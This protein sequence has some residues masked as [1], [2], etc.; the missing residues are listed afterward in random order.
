MRETVPDPQPRVAAEPTDGPAEPIARGVYNG[1]RQLQRHWQQASLPRPARI[2]VI[3]GAVLLLI[4]NLEWLLPVGAVLTLFYLPYLAVF[5]MFH[6]HKSP[7][8]P[9]VHRAAAVVRP[10]PPR[11]PAAPRQRRRRQTSRAQ[12]ETEARVSLRERTLSER[13]GE[14][15]GGLL[16]ASIVSVVACLVMVMIGGQSIE[17]IYTWTLFGWLAMTSVAGSWLILGI[18]KLWEGGPGEDLQRRFIMLVAGLALGLVAYASSQYLDVRAGNQLAVSSLPEVDA[19]RGMYESDRTPKLP[20]FLVYF[21]GIF[22]VTRWWLQSDPIR[23]VRLSLWST[24]I[25]LLWAWIIHLIWPFPQP[26]GLMLAAA[27]SLSVQLSAPWMSSTTRNSIR[28][29]ISEA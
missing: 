2:A 12:W 24:A 15:S 20:V 13:L 7:S 22:L 6:A 9:T 28:S 29:R 26:W 19:W 27:I 18:S 14:L 8:R 17:S 10:P 16:S 11:E 4:L 5:H 23:P 25:C 1:F 3:V 21:A